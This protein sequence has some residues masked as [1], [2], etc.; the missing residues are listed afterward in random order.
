MQAEEQIRMFEQEKSHWWYLALQNFL[1]RSLEPKEE[2]KVLDLGCGSGHFLS[3]LKER[4]SCEAEG[5]ELSSLAVEEARA[6]GLKVTQMD[7]L[8][9]LESAPAE[10]YHRIYCLDALYFFSPES[11]KKIFGHIKRCLKPEGTAIVH[12]P[13][14]QCF[15]REH[16]LTVGIQK[17]TSVK[18]LRQLASAT[19]LQPVRWRYRVSALSLLLLP[20]KVWQKIYAAPEPRTDLRPIPSWLNSFLFAWQRLEDSLPSF[21]WGSSLFME[22]S[23]DN[24]A[25]HS[26]PLS[27]HDRMSAPL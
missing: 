7:I 25:K 26:H 11:Q 15:A 9:F 5:V 27:R 22:L 1:L 3:L 20:L 2:L 6:K 24:L 12:A 8:Q 13:A 14:L 19:G 18:E 23:G 17:R 21:P 16:D 10:T 4:L